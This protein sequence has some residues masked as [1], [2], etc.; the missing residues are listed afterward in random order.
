MADDL[1]KNSQAVEWR[2]ASPFKLSFSI[3]KY[4]YDFALPS[5]KMSSK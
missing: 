5:R 3:N 4:N 1:F 2:R